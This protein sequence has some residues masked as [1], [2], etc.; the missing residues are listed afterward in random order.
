MFK[1]AWLSVKRKKTKSIILFLFLFIISNL[2]LSAISIKNAT[3]ESMNLA[4][5]SLG[6]EVSLSMNMEKL[7]NNFM[8]N[9]EEPSIDDKKEN[10]EKMHDN[11]DESNI[12][13]SDVDKLKNIKYVKDIK[14]TFSVDGE[15]SSFK[16]YSNSTEEDGENKDF[17][18]RDN[19]NN[20]LQIEAINTFKLQDDYVNKIIELTEGEAFDEDDNDT[21]II[22]YE[23]ANSNNLSINDKIKVKDSSGNEHELTIIGIYQNTDSRGFNNYNKIYINTSTGE[24]F[25]S[26]DDYNNGNYKVSSAVFYLDNPENSD[27]FISKAKKLITDLDDRYL[28]LDI[29]KESYEQMVSSLEGVSKFSN[30][31]LIVVVL[32]SI[33]VISLMVI[34]SLKDRNYEIG[35]LLS[36]GEKK[37]KIVGQFI[38]ELI[39]IATIAFVLS[40]GSSSLISQ[41]LADTVLESQNK[42]ENRMNDSRQGG[43]GN[44]FSPFNMNKGKSNVNVIDEID[45][46]VNKEDIGLLFIV[47]YGIIFISMIVPSIKIINSD[48][49]DILSRRE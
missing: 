5:K 44:D 46:N 2:V 13:K 6:G 11:M 48:P 27:K 18:K 4:K 1:R 41:K 12:T 15:E 34:N 31:I 24:K 43:R 25:L 49:K 7:R 36:L 21:V 26:E 33:V 40:I 39:L 3:T 8:D 23:L 9:K 20:S 32:A 22:S 37:K 10:M 42:V 45:V 14:Y 47:G 19:M 30:T 28:K 35:V 38:I 17:P 29:D 16:L